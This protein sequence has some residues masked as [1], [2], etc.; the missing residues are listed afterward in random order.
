M[1]E[2]KTGDLALIVVDENPDRIGKCVELVRL[3]QSNEWYI[4]PVECELPLGM[5]HNASGS[6]VWLVLGDVSSTTYGGQLIQG[7]CQKCP[8]RLMPL[9]GDF[10]PERQKS[11]ELPA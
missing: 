4:P 10:A 11:Q 5:V 3:V 1:H 9:R 6:A 7:F 2:F 8:T